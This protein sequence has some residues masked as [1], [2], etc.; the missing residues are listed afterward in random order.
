MP[1]GVRVSLDTYSDLPQH[2]VPP[3]D[4][5]KAQVARICSDDAFADRT[6]AAHLLEYL[7]EI[8]ND[9]RY[10]KPFTRDRPFPTGVLILRE[11]YNYRFKTF[12]EDAPNDPATA[13]KKLVAELDD[14]LKE[15]YGPNP[16]PEIKG[17]IQIKIQR[18]RSHAYRPLISWI[19]EPS[20]A[21]SVNTLRDAFG[22]RVLRIDRNLSAVQQE[23]P[24]QP[25][26]KAIAGPD[27]D[28]S[29]DPAARLISR[30]SYSGDP[31]TGREIEEDFLLAT[32][33]EEN[34][35]IQEVAT[36]LE[37][38]TRDVSSLLDRA[39]ALGVVRIDIRKT[40]EEEIV[41]RLQWKYPKLEKVF[42]VPGPQIKTEEQ[43]DDF[44]RRSGVLAAAYFEQLLEHQPRGKPFHVGVGG[45]ARLLEFAKAVRPRDRDTV[46]VQTT[47]LIG[48]TAWG[49]NTSFVEPSV[50]AT[51]LWTRCGSVD[52]K[53]CYATVEPY[54]FEKLHQQK[55]RG[56]SESCRA[57]VAKE[58]AR[59]ENIQNIKLV[60]E[61][62]DK[63]DAVFAS[64]GPVKIADEAVGIQ[65]RIGIGKLVG[66]FVSEAGLAYED[67][68][69]EFSYCFFDA[70]G[71]SDEAWRFF[72][73]A[74]HY[75]KYPG[76]EF[77]KH[78]VAGGKKVV[79]IGG[80]QVLVPVIMAAL[81][82]EII[83]VLIIDYSTAR[84]ISERH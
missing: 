50:V 69:G 72:L 79:G 43:C 15:F 35:R 64:F 32:S 19:G 74:G 39:R 66:P 29:H 51:A 17:R 56:E 54:W 59:L 48:R 75:S 28:Q 4:L 60:I 36:S 14:A 65:R 46:H 70:N 2:N 34:A 30:S 18:G 49:E 5:V 76:I 68:I 58:I 8:E 22:G 78:M 16:D 45:G 61:E 21:G 12:H 52:G 63:L 40:V 6:R 25:Q 84:I 41:A 42:I 24:P 38:G 11:F 3:N 10:C 82:A 77:Y 73:T 80:S 53:C 23:P 27:L 62:M 67:V 33:Q 13:G 37:I 20:S 1:F 7:V 57:I 47:A 9:R 31:Q 71:N 83:N 81:N 44:I 55:K 26:D